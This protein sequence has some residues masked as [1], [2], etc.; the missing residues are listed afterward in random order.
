MGIGFLGPWRSSLR[1]VFQCPASRPVAILGSPPTQYPHLLC[2]V[3]PVSLSASPV[4]A[5]GVIFVPT[6]LSCRDVKDT[7]ELIEGNE[8]LFTDVKTLPR[9]FRT[10]SL[11]PGVRPDS[12]SP[13]STT[14]PLVSSRPSSETSFSYV[15]RSEDPSVEEG[16]DEGPVGIHPETKGKD[17]PLRSLK[18]LDHPIPLSRELVP[19][20]RTKSRVSEQEPLLPSRRPLVFVGSRRTFQS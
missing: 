5:V 6:N 7:P 4:P 16:P 9:P 1:V 19:S 20:P 10:S 12:S 17:L 11:Y 18:K 8:H 15:V 2:P 3:L 14:S 13:P